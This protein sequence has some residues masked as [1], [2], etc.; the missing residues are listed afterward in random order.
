ML[1]LQSAPDPIA[2]KTLW[3]TIVSAVAA[4]VSALA[5]GFA[6]YLGLKAPTKEDLKRIEEN[7]HETSIHIDAAREHLACEAQRTALQ[8]RASRVSVEVTGWGELYKPLTMRF[9]LNDTGAILFRVDLINE[10][11]MLT[12]SAL[13][14]AAAPLHYAVEVTPEVVR[15]W[16]YS[17]NIVSG[18][19]GR[20]LQI[21][22][23]LRIIDEETS[24]TFSVRLV[25]DNRPN[26]SRPGLTEAFWTVEGRC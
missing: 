16:Y 6:V 23:H 24:R 25:R 13:C 1:N 14:V 8:T 12:G 4:I 10:H 5:A 9:T 22:A 18:A 2:V 20:L 11:H 19:L 17:G 21:R 7:T 26:P 15:D 3:W